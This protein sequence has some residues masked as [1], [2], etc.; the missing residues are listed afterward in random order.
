VLC[1]FSRFLPRSAFNIS[2]GSGSL[3]QCRACK[4]LD[5]DARTRLDL[6]LYKQLLDSIKASGI[7][8]NFRREINMSKKC[9][10]LAQAEEEARNNTN[11]PAFILQESDIR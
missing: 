4:Q 11:S 7:K 2:A 10:F 9:N 8:S 1:A 5:N 6:S 3:A